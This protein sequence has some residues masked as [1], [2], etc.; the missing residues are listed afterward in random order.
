MGASKLANNIGKI[1][2]N[3]SNLIGTL[4]IGVN[5]ILWGAGNTQPE[6]KTEYD[7]VSGSF[8]YTTNIPQNPTPPKGNL[9]N[10]GL[11]NALDAL[12]EVDLCN[13]L[14][15]AFDNINI[16]K[17]PRPSKPWNAPQEA[18]YFLQDQAA[19]V[20]Q[21]I[22]KYTA[23]PTEFVGSYIGTG[24][25]AVSPA[26]VATGSN[27]PAPTGTEAQKYNL[28]F[29]MK[30]I[31]ETFATDTPG[32]GSLFTSE[33]ITL[34]RTVP[35]LGGNLNIIDDFIGTIN[36][37]SDYR[38]IPNED[39]QNLINKVATIRS[40]CVTIQNLDF[41]SAL[42]LAGNF[43]GID[44][45]AQIQKLGR[46]IDVTKLIPTLKGI[47]SSLQGF[48]KIAQQAQGILSLGQFIIKL[49]LLFYKIFKFIILFFDLLALPLIF[50]TAGTQTKL[51]DVKDK[52]KDETDGVVRLLR[53]VNG[54][55][56]V[57]TSFIRYLLTNANEL[58]I[59]LRILLTQLEGCEAVRNSDV[60]LQLQQ[61]EKDLI[62]V[63]DQLA[64][65]IREYDSKTNPNSAL[66]GTY[67]IRVVDEELVDPSIPNKRRRGIALNLNGNIVTQSDLTFAT[68]T[69]LIIDEVKQKLLALQLVQP[70][71]GQIDPINLP[72]ISESLNFLEN[73]D[74]L[75]NDLN[76]DT[77]E[78]SNLAATL[79]ALN[80][81][82]QQD[83][84]LGL[85]AFIDD[86]KGGKKLR[87]RT[88]EKVAEQSASVKTQVSSE[89]NTSTQT[90]KTNN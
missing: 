71:L 27:A 7:T 45:R 5:K 47:N 20:Q 42:A 31:K 50:G 18:L 74:V 13:V 69:S 46:F 23:Y 81:P 80:I 37:Y 89:I 52:A 56:T 29:L 35:G 28:F 24:P 83:Q 22:D 65:F 72:V 59:R 57:L 16:K 2:T 9:L 82:V 55:L 53:A 21:A 66:F 87:Q 41:K 54:L 68:N 34:L 85:N 76:I 61:T 77:S 1:V 58:L 6:M 33:D 3:T 86:L 78:N 63:R 30:A 8:S 67:D 4:Q 11:F 51:Q 25:N 39:L 26:V 79:G 32:T 49:A 12:N 64:S 38:Q 60:I 75:Q 62:I 10:S 17:K 43:L 19:F 70:A 73:N 84:G 36:K 90:L 88:K 40:V 48:I 15:Y 44:I 14:T